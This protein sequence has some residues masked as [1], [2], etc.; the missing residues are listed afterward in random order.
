LTC[1]V[2][3]LYDDNL[4]MKKQQEKHTYEPSLSCARKRTKDEVEYS[5][6]AF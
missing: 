3:A 5:E 1:Y 6:F 4:D 2:I